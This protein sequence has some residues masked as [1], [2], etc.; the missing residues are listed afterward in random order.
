[1]KVCS[2]CEGVGASTAHTGDTMLSDN[3][4]LSRLLP[5]VFLG[6]TSGPYAVPCTNTARPQPNDA[7]FTM[8]IA[9]PHKGRGGESYVRVTYIIRS[10]PKESDCALGGKSSGQAEAKVSS[11]VVSRVYM[12][13]SLNEDP[14]FPSILVSD[15]FQHK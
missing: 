3:P 2:V 4:R 13:L 5:G 8:T 10:L 1:M 15:G 7:A 11:I 14:V 6:P 12:R 9:R